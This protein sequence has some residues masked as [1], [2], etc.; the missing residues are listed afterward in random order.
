MSST[1]LVTVQPA[2]NYGGNIVSMKNPDNSAYQTVSDEKETGLI[3]SEPTAA[4]NILVESETSLLHQN[5][6][7]Y[8]TNR[9][10]STEKQGGLPWSESPNGPIGLSVY[11][12]ML[13][14]LG[15]L[16]ILPGT[17][18]GFWVAV[19]LLVVISLGFLFLTHQTDPGRIP[20]QPL[21]DPLVTAVESG[22]MEAAAAGIW[23]GAYGQWMRSPIRQ[24]VSFSGGSV[25][26]IFEAP[27][28]AER[29]CATCHIWRPPRASHCSVCNFCFQRFD[30]HC[31][32]MGTCIARDNHRFF[33][34]FL[35]CSSGACMTLAT[36]GLMRYTGHFGESAK[37]SLSSW[38]FY[39]GGGVLA[40]LC[41]TSFVGCFAASHCC[42]LLCNL[43]SKQMAMSTTDANDWHTLLRNSFLG[44]KANMAEVWC[45]DVRWKHSLLSNGC[46]EKV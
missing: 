36:A 46:D 43:T 26:T 12:V 30:H 28:D 21:P 32:A 20:P 23:R 11:I 31:P 10:T 1:V 16:F 15:F 34:M 39:M 27:E 7:E 42:L 35:L 9:L 41:Y 4:S 8:S 44:A 38:Q 29:Y 37:P 33:V 24:G 14:S 19:G 18:V 22:E 45:G 25:P 17:P 6:S 5:C 3:L 2:K 13:A 40:I